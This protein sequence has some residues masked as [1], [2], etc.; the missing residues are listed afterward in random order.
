MHIRWTL[1]QRRP[2]RIRQRYLMNEMNE[3]VSDILVRKIWGGKGDQAMT[4]H[5]EMTHDTKEFMMSGSGGGVLVR[6]AQAHPSAL[7]QMCVNGARWRVP[8]F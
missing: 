8:P 2:A 7:S 5:F 1:S 6:A 3:S 4:V